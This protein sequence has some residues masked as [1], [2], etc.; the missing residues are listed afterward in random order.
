MNNIYLLA[1]NL[2]EHRREEDRPPLK[3]VETRARTRLRSI[4]VARDASEIDGS[5]LKHGRRKK[6]VK[7]VLDRRGVSPMRTLR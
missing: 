4:E 5:L 6:L 7:K 3:D 2:A 1:E